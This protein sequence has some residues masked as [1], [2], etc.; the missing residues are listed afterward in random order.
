ME[1]IELSILIPVFNEE[2]SINELFQKL[3]AVLGRL[4]KTYEI[5][6]IDDGSTDKTLDVI[7]GIG[8]GSGRIR[9]VSFR[10]NFGKSAALMAGFEHA[11]GDLIITMDGD[12]QDDSEEIPRF[13]EKLGQNYDL[14]VGWKARRQDPIGK[15]TVSRIFNM[16]TAMLTG[17]K[18]HDFNCC[19]KIFTKELVQ[20]L[21]IHGELHRYIPALAHW[22]GYRVSEIEVKHNARKYGKSKY[23]FSRLF[24]GFLDL[25][26]VKF[27][28]SYLT[29][30]IHFFGQAGLI[31][32]FLGGALGI[33]SLILKFL[34][35]MPLSSSQLPLLTVFMIIVG[36]QFILMGLL[37]EILVRIYYEPGRKSFYSV[38]E[39]INF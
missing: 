35:N 36:I 34:F 32:L 33:I 4:N 6:F 5:I 29:R 7:K 37:A 25:I 3:E 14:V 11:Q 12:L 2:E 8:L 13:L 28:M 24:K 27:I 20:N 1:K 30:P 19:F 31:L 22:Q 9:A 10:R 17:V 23:G 18:I 39:K 38:R 26:T 21:K 16:L 15:R